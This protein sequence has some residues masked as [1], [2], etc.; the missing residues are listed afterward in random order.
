MGHMNN[1]IHLLISRTKRE[2]RQKV[3]GVAPPPSK[4]LFQFFYAI[5]DEPEDF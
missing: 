3:S 1:A 5:D 4:Y 2:T